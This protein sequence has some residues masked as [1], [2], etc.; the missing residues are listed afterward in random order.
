MVRLFT[1]EVC[2]FVVD[3]LFVFLV[4]EWLLPL[5]ERLDVDGLVELD[6]FVVLDLL[7]DDDRDADRPPP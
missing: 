4:D 5:N 2:L 7:I 1:L 6:L 3:V